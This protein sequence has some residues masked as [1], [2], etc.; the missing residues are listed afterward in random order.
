VPAAAVLGSVVVLSLSRTAL[1]AAV[2]SIALWLIFVP[3]RLRMAALL[4]VAGAGTAAICAW[5][6]THQA[7]TGDGAAL[8]ARDSAGHAFGVVLL[9][10]LAALFAAGPALARAGD[11]VVL[12]E[13]TR[14]RLGRILIGLL[15]LV[16][17][18]VVIALASS[19]R[20][21]TG[22]ISHAWSSL[23]SVNAGVSNSASRITQFGSS[24]PLYW[25]EGIAVGDH[26]LFKGVGALGF[27]TA[28]TR[29]TTNTHVVGHAHSYLVQTFADLGLLG[30]VVS[31]ALVVA[32]ARAAVR[33][34]AGFRPWTELDPRAAGE[35]RGLVALLI[36]TIG[37]GLVSSVDW[38]WYFPSVTVPAL[39]AAGWLAG[40]GPLCDPVGPARP[41]RSL[42]GRPLV[43]SASGAL[44]L[45]AL[46][47]AW[48][49]W[50]PL[51]SADA[52][53]AAISAAGRGQG[54][55]AFADARSAQAADP[56]A[57]QPRFVLASLYTA[58]GQPSAA[59]QELVGAVDLQPENPN[60]WLQLGLNDLDSG[61][62]RLAV[63][64][65]LRS[66]LL[67]PTVPTT[68]DAL[69]RAWAAARPSLG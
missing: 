13:P 44:T 67:N 37:Y 62:P 30:L 41:R 24:R 1:V 40:R 16:P 34:V 35:R 43:L 52:D 42:L 6:L 54:P 5:A 28:R 15:A 66:Y 69:A 8:S 9:I 58:A 20:G 47:A 17:V 25:S 36:A 64:E 31:L 14:Q 56:L 63:S 59:R 68:I 38:T 18:A 33:A 23:T 65:L 50:Q 46:A 21:L 48:L 7:L 10:V 51:R 11:T 19:S 61:H 27:A 32:W 29:Y 45:V 22:E 26:A 12:A 3:G 39:L 4:G 60:S 57:L 49:I 2:V 55:V 53:S